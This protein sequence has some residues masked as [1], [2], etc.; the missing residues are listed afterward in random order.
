MTDRRHPEVP[1]PIEVP[2]LHGTEGGRWKV[3]TL[4]SVH[5]FD[6]NHPRTVT[7]YP[8]THS[9]PS[10]NDVTRELLD[11]GT[12]VV[13]RRGYWTMKPDNYLLDHYWQVTSLIQAITRLPDEPVDDGE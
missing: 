9:Q 2:E 13:G 12:C 1:E 4:G 11:I 8:G 7:R 6:F 5:I 3:Q 10:I